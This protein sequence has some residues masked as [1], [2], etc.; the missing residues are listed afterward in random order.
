MTAIVAGHPA[1]TFSHSFVCYW[2]CFVAVAVLWRVLSHIFIAPNNFCFSGTLSLLL[3][4][5]CTNLHDASASV[6]L[7]CNTD[8]APWST[9]IALLTFCQLL[10]PGGLCTILAFATIFVNIF[11]LCLIQGFWIIH[12]TE[13]EYLLAG[14]AQVPNGHLL[15]VTWAQW[16]SVWEHKANILLLSVLMCRL[17]QHWQAGWGCWLSLCHGHYIPHDSLCTKQGHLIHIARCW[18]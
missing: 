15:I 8:S 10:F 12:S 1:R 7:S 13:C 4:A 9:H 3:F 16:I 18:K 5:A 2:L 17:Q 14:S 6:L 11:F